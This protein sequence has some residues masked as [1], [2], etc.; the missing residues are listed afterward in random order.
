MPSNEDKEEMIFELLDSIFKRLQSLPNRP[1]S[2]LEEKDLIMGAIVCKA[3]THSHVSLCALFEL[4]SQFDSIVLLRAAYEATIVS[5]FLHRNPNEYERYCAHS[6]LVELGN[7]R[8]IMDM[9]FDELE[10]EG[11]KDSLEKLQN[12][13]TEISEQ[14]LFLKAGLR[15]E[16]W[17]NWKDS[18]EFRKK[19]KSAHFIGFNQ[20]TES[21]RNEET[22]RVLIKLGFQL[23]NLG[24]QVAHSHHNMVSAFALQMF[25]PAY[26]KKSVYRVLTYLIFCNV[27]TLK[28]QGFLADEMYSSIEAELLKALAF[29]REMDSPD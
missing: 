1:L 29:I 6:K 19:T 3:L 16:E 28:E 5:A 13:H 24:S 27:L 15:E 21:L 23:Y 7:Q 22:L 14:K 25:H 20:M 2:N 8:E 10:D 17:N 9:V 11:K 12:L 4:N 26:S 18:K